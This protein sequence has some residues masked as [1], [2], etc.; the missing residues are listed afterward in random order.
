M[1]LG[2]FLVTNGRYVER[3]AAE[4]RAQLLIV[5][6]NQHSG[7]THLS[8]LDSNVDGTQLYRETFLK[9]TKHLSCILSELWS[10]RWHDPHVS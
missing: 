10:K 6:G 5:C 1:L 9:K 2:H 3:E 7:T 4:E 8:R